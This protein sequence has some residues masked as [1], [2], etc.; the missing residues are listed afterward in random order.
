M[1]ES[2]NDRVD[3]FEDESRRSIVPGTLPVTV[4]TRLEEASKT[5][6]TRPYTIASRHEKRRSS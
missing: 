4:G 5:A 2:V 1:N 3:T 6:S